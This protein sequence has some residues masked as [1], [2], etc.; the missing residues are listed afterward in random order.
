LPELV[1]VVLEASGLLAH[2][3]TEKE[4]ADRIENLEQMVSAATQFVSEEGFGQGAPAHL[5]PQAQAQ[6]GAPIVNQDGFEIIDADAPL[7]TV[8]S[9]L[10]AFLSH[11]SL[12]AGDNQATGRPGGRA[13]DDGALGQGAGVQQRLHHRPGRR[14]F[15]HESSSREHDGVDEERRLMYVAITRAREAPLHE[16]YANP[17]A[18]RPDPLQ[19]EIA[20]LR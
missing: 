9:P 10:S 6:S 3:E 19:H 4:G 20:L 18:A 5:G 8:M 11:A 12:E 16:L 17:H 15:P 2:Y 7:A 13:D 14:L 1:R